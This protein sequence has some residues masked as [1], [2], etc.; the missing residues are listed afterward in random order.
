MNA[1]ECR[2][3]QPAF[4]ASPAAREQEIQPRTQKI[5]PRAFV[6]SPVPVPSDGERAGVSAEI[7]TFSQF[8]EVLCDKNKD[9][10]STRSNCP[11]RRF[12][13]RTY[14]ALARDPAAPAAG[15]ILTVMWSAEFFH[16]V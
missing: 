7:W 1:L 5:L 9:L 12:A 6:V 11:V 13:S 15:K 14:K 2:I 3:S 8:S 4:R 16:A 10:R